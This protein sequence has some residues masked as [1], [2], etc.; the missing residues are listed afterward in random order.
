LWSPN[1][2]MGL[3][4]CNILL[5]D[6]EQDTLLKY[7]NLNCGV[8]LEILWIS[9]FE[10]LKKSVRYI[11][12]NCVNLENSQFLGWA[13]ICV[14]LVVGKIG[15]VLPYSL[16]SVGPRADLGVQAVSLQVNLSHP[17]GGRLP[18]VS[19]RHAVTFPAVGRY[20]IILLGDR[21]TGM[22][23]VCP[24]RYLEPSEPRFEPATNT[25]ATQQW[26]SFTRYPRQ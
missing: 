3:Q 8:I 9:V 11:V 25:L 15:A 22:W 19:A 21:G 23:A 10:S 26:P 13:L 7:E 14:M 5:D 6:C 4:C 20:Q 12:K 1:P 17:P 18:L 16:P 24:R 2:Q